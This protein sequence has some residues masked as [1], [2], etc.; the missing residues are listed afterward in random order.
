[1][2]FTDISITPYGGPPAYLQGLEPP[3]PQAPEGNHAD[4]GEAAIAGGNPN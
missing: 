1:M 2:Q 3:Y 4:D